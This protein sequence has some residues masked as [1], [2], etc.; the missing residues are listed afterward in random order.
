M[1]EAK[2]TEQIVAA[3]IEEINKHP[4]NAPRRVKVVVGEMFHLEPESVKMHY[5]ILTKGSRLEGVKLDLVED[6][7]TVL[8]RSCGK[9]DTV[10]DHH[11][12]MCQHCSSQQVELKSGKAIQV[13]MIEFNEA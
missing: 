2:F 5:R 3:I 12:L 6:P 13:E 9:T 1:H 8:C 11:L 10:E 4:N 7:V